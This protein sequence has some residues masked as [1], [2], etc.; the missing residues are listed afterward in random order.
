MVSCEEFGLSN[1]FARGSVHVTKSLF[2]GNGASVRCG[3]YKQFD[4]K[5]EKAVFVI[6]SNVLPAAESQGVKPDMFN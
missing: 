5:Y 2:E 4:K 1:A 6:A 3:L